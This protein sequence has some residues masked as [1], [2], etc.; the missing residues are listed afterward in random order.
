[1]S[2]LFKYSSLLIILFLLFSSSDIKSVSLSLSLLI[3]CSKSSFSFLLRNKC[4]FFWNPQK[5]KTI[6]SLY[7]KADKISIKYSAN[8]IKNSPTSISL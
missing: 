1:M 5:F 7:T 8:L 4:V 2:L 3:I 6:N